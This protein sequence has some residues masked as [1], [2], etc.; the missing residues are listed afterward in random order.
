MVLAER[1]PKAQ[2]TSC[3]IYEDKLDRMREN[4]E[5]CHLGNIET[6]LLDATEHFEAY[7]GAFDVV[8]CDAPCSGLGVMGK[9]QDIKY[10]LTEESIESIVALQKKILEN[11]DTYVKKGGYLCYSTCTLNKDEND[12]QVES[13][14]KDHD[15]TLV[16]PTYIP[17]RYKAFVSRNMVQFIQGEDTDGFFFSILKKNG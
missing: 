5:R 16:A 9:K 13:F 6:K 12:R 17:E 15:Y 4:F 2:I 14:L 11:L 7:E 1:Y 3:D 8:V 10:N